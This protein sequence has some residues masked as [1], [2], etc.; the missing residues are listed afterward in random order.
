MLVQALMEA[1]VTERRSPVRHLLV[2]TRQRQGKGPN[3]C[4]PRIVWVEHLRMRRLTALDTSATPVPCA[5]MSSEACRF[6]SP[7]APRSGS[8]TPPFWNCR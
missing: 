3:T 8:P 7:L 6:H 1:D 4:H 5:V 2:R